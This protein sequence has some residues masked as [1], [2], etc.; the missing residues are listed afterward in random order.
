MGCFKKLNSFEAKSFMK[1]FALSYCLFAMALDQVHKRENGLGSPSEA[2][3]ADGS[4][5]TTGALSSALQ[6]AGTW[7]QSPQ[8]DRRTHGRLPV[9]EEAP[10][11]HHSSHSTSEGAGSL[12]LDPEDIMLMISAFSLALA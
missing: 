9:T 7:Y 6:A 2:R 1:C 10:D 11:P 3:S 12:D 4:V 5:W 8:N